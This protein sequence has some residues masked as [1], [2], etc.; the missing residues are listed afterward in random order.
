MVDMIFK[1]DLTFLIF[2]VSIPIFTLGITR[3]S[4]SFKIATIIFIVVGIVLLFT[5]TFSIQAL[6][7]AVTSMIDIVVLLVVMQL[8]MLPVTVGNY[9]RAVEQFMENKLHTP[10]SIYVFVML[11][12]HLLSSILSMGTVSIVISV[13]GDSIKKELLIM[14]ISLVPL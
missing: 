14:S 3:L 10:R 11:I 6:S 8:F 12:T 2:L 1:F 7:K 5:G 4:N 9:Q 13:L